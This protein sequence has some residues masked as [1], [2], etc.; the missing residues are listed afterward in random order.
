[1]PRTMI[2][3]AIVCGALPE[4]MANSSRSASTLVKPPSPS[5]WQGTGDPHLTAS[6]S[7]KSIWRLVNVI[8]SL[9][10]DPMMQICITFLRLSPLRSGQPTGSI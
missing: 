7:R 2:R 8:D 5:I 10:F 1:M 6:F 3:R 4:S 9:G